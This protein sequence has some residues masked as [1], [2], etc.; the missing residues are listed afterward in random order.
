MFKL[1]FIVLIAI[2]TFYIFY[3]M[4][5]GK[6]ISFQEEICN[7]VIEELKRHNFTDLDLKEL[8]VKFEDQ[9]NIIGFIYLSIYRYDGKF[10]EIK[11]DCVPELNIWYSMADLLVRDF[12]VKIGD[13]YIP[14]EEL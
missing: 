3:R 7:Y 5:R 1:L 4:F 9:R 6:K 8:E 2:T 12:I 11:T 13:T 14:K 10:V